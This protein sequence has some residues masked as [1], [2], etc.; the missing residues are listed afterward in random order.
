MLSVKIGFFPSLDLLP[1][2]DLYYDCFRWILRKRHP[3]ESASCSIP[4]WI[5][6]WPIFLSS[7]HL[8]YPDWMAQH[9]SLWIGTMIDFSREHERRLFGHSIKLYAYIDYV[10]MIDCIMYHKSGTH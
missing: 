8:S 10:D 9:L 2:Q 1:L 4:S 3:G 5:I 6:D 7:V